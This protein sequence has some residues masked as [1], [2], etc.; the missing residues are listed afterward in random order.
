MEAKTPFNSARLK[1]FQSRLMKIKAILRDGMGQIEN[2]SLK[3]SGRDASGDLSNLP[4]HL[5][6]AGSDTFEQDFSLGILEGEDIEVKE[7]DEA[8]ERIENKTYGIC[9]ECSTPIAENRLKVIPYARLCVKCQES[10]EKH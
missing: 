8:L 10:V 1:E 2:N 5:A 7:V 4:I 9:E 6:D 3:K